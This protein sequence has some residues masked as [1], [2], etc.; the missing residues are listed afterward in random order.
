MA[1]QGLKTALVAG[2]TGLVGSRREFR[3]GARRA[4]GRAHHPVGRNAALRHVAVYVFA[5]Q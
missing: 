4:A 2:A 3:R 5:L 1:D